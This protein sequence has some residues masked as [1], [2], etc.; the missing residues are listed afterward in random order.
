[1]DASKNHSFKT[2]PSADP[3]GMRQVVGILPRFASFSH[4]W[5]DLF[6]QAVPK[7]MAEISN[8]RG[9]KIGRTGLISGQFLTIGR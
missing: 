4:L 7:S 6:G 1:M 2:Q 3:G 5:H 9:R 8:D